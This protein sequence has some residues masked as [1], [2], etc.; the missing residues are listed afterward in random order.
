MKKGDTINGYTLLNDFTNAGAGMCQWAF[1]QRGGKEYFI[2]VFLSPIYPTEG[3]LGSPEKKAK[4]KIECE[5]FENHHRKLQEVLSGKC[6]EGSNLVV[7]RDFFRHDTKYYKITD[8]VDVSSITI[9]NIATLVLPKKMIILMTIAKSVQI[10]H[11][12]KIVHGDLK[13]DNILI[14]ET[15]PN[16]FTA[17]LIDFDNSYFSGNPLEVFDDIVGDLTYYSPEMAMF[18][19]KDISS[20]ISLDMLKTNSDIFSLGIIFYQYITGKLP[21]INKKYKTPYAAVLDNEKICFPSGFP[22][23]LKSLLTQMVNKDFEKRPNINEVFNELKK[24]Y[25]DPSY[26]PGIILIDPPPPKPE[27]KSKRKLIIGEGFSTS[28]DTSKTEPPP[29]SS[30]KTGSRL[31]GTGLGASSSDSKMDSPPLEIPPKTGSRLRGTGLK[32]D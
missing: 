25:D 11:R 18:I 8:K 1:A 30:P 12:E 15:V 5:K 28:S 7:T 9:P 24:I 14:K 4:Q 16:I 10:L 6:G 23:K 17:K 2:K 22:D 13:P 3:A 29:E 32:K 31:R 21:F 27:P 19:D 26:I 20:G